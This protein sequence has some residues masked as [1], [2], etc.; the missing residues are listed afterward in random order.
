MKAYLI[1][2]CLKKWQ[3]VKISTQR[4]TIFT[5]AHPVI[6]CKLGDSNQHILPKYIVA[7]SDFCKAHLLGKCLGVRR[8]S[9]KLCLSL[10]SACTRHLHDL[11]ASFRQQDEHAGNTTRIV[12]KERLASAQQNDSYLQKNEAATSLMRCGRLFCIK[13]YCSL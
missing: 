7:R 8:K 6:F 9:C 12:D 2:Y 3:Y 11:E 10:R 1:D 13:K 5:P 4:A